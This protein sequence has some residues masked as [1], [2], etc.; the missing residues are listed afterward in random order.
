M[1]AKKIVSL[2]CLISLIIIGG[3]ACGRENDTGNQKQAKENQ[4]IIDKNIDIATESPD[5]NKED[6]T[7]ANQKMVDCGLA[8]DPGCFMNRMNGCL[9]VTTKMTGSDAKT[10]IEV[11]ILG[12]EN[13]KCH[14]QRKINNIMDL[15]C[16]FPKGTMNSDTF[17]QMFGNDKGLQKVV[18]DACKYPTE[19]VGW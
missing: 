18:D 5:K 11:T 16:F 14:F 1:N 4:P 7:V 10:A 9:P 2:F 15:N 12:V 17:N 8:E 19:N 6:L 13:E 3:T